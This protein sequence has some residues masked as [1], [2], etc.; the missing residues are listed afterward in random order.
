[1]GAELPPFNGRGLRAMV[2]FCRRQKEGSFFFLGG[3]W[4]GS[5]FSPSAV[6]PPPTLQAYIHVLSSVEEEIVFPPW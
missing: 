2:I 4:D 6:S 1:M 5:S 3:T